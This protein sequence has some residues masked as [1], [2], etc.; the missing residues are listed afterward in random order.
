MRETLEISYLKMLDL[1]YLLHLKT[2]CVILIITS[3]ALVNVK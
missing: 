2:Y 3:I 1:V